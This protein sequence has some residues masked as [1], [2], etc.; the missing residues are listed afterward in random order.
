LE[1]GGEEIEVVDGLA[2]DSRHVRRKCESEAEILGKLNGG[3]VKA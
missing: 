1:Q 2:A 3:V